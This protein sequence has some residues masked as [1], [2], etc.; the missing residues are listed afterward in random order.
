MLRFVMKRPLLFKISQDLRQVFPSESFSIPE[1]KLKGSALDV[2]EQDQE[3]IG[4]D[5]SMLGGLPKK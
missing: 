4:I 2:A 5:E 1:G 3:V